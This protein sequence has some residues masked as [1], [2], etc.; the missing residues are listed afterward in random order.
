[1]KIF[2]VIPLTPPE[3][4]PEDWAAILQE[5]NGPGHEYLATPE[6]RM[7][8]LK[9]LVEE[10]VWGEAI[11]ITD[12]PEFPFWRLVPD[13]VVVQDEA[14][15]KLGKPQRTTD[16]GEW[17]WGITIESVK[18]SDITKARKNA[19]PTRE[20]MV[21][22]LAVRYS[23]GKSN[24]RS[25][26]ETDGTY[27]LI[28]P[29]A[30]PEIREKILADIESGKLWCW[31]SETDQ[32]NEEDSDSPNPWSAKLVDISISTTP[33]HAYRIPVNH[34][35]EEN[36][37]LEDLFAFLRACYE[38]TSAASS[39]VLL[40]N[41]KYD[42]SVMAN[43]IQG[44]PVKEI[45]DHWLPVTIDTMLAAQVANLRPAGLK[46]L[47][48]THLGVKTIDFKKLTGGKPF[49]QVP[50]EPAN[51]Y[52]GQD[53]DWPLRLWPIISTR[54]SELGVREVYQRRLV[55]TEFFMRAERRGLLPNREQLQE[56]HDGAIA[57]RERCLN[58]LVTALIDA[59]VPLKD[60]FNPGSS[61]Q[62]ARALFA[63]T[64]AGLGLPVLERTK[65]GAASAGAKARNALAI[66]GISHPALSWLK[67]WSEH[68]KRVTASTGP[69]LT[70]FI[71]SDGRVHPTF[72]VAAA[73]TGRTS[74]QLPNAQQFDEELASCFE[75]E[76]NRESGGMG[77]L[78]DIDYSQIE[79]RVMAV[80][81]LEPKML[82]T[83]NQPR[84]I[85]D[86]AGNLVENPDAD[87]HS[88][89]QRETGAKTR[90]FAKNLNFGKA[91]RAG[92][93]TLSITTGVPMNQVAPFSRAFDQSYS[94][95]TR[96]IKLREREAADSGL[97][98]TWEG[99]VRLLP[100]ALTDKKKAENGRLVANTPVQGGAAGIM[101]V[102]IERALPLIRWAEGVGIHP[103]NMIHDALYFEREPRTPVVVW[104]R[105]L[106]GIIQIMEAANP[107]PNQLPIYTDIKVG[108]NWGEDLHTP[109]FI[110][111]EETELVLAGEAD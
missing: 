86:D 74:C 31:D 7:G 18:K 81:F 98:R 32:T 30:F 33:G 4:R 51:V 111:V 45:Y 36:L 6:D 76:S 15:K 28:T 5:I 77:E 80:E 94:E 9:R 72:N 8:W 26:Y 1:M 67:R 66:A 41:C 56:L 14:G 50:T 13:R 60:D 100:P 82:E 78:A 12:R 49:S 57:E 99:W 16:L 40:H 88:R 24:A 70:K 20:I 37:P 39:H 55:V 46:P 64:P 85:Y 96:N 3:I 75:A 83:Y 38:A 42:Y 79:L 108:K 47:A 73:E 102:A 34:D 68:Q 58:G 97:V 90:R 106:Q 44:F 17:A 110:D 71:Q 84:F 69:M 48:R 52:A 92:D 104:H 11:V 62:L 101:F 53:A 93:A 2:D 22:G 19:T 10:E 107:W 89:T 43:P 61:Q 105:F 29:G 87:I 91:F 109:S 21:E 103:F 59:G 25:L 27:E 35:G 63:P 23:E 54:L 65:T 95:L